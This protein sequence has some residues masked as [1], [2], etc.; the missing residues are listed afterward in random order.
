MGWLES[1]VPLLF[2]CSPLFKVE[3]NKGGTACCCGWPAVVEPNRD[4]VG[5]CGCARLLKGL[6][7]GWAGFDA[8]SPPKKL[9]PCEVEGWFT[10]FA[11]LL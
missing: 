4:A 3:P 9:V 11:V 1:R 7:I 10:E 2:R 6:E 5:C 8:L